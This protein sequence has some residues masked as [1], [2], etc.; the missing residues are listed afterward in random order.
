MIT[1][2]N[3]RTEQ[4]GEWTRLVCDFV[5]TEIPVRREKTNNGKQ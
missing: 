1:L 2:S 5:W 4:A 3:L